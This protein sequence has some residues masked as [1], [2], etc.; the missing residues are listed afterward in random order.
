MGQFHDNT[1][2]NEDGGYRVARDELLKAEI[3]LRKQIEAVAAMRRALPP[4]GV[5]EDYEF[6][7]SSGRVRLSE[8][9]ENGRESLVIYSFMYGPDWEAPCPM[10]TAMLDGMDGQIPHVR[11]R[12]NFAVVAKAP[13]AK[14]EAF[15]ESRGWSNLPLLSSEGNTYNAD[16]FAEN[17][18]GQWPM[19]NVFHR[20]GAEVRHTWGSELFLTPPDDGLHNRHA[21]L[22]WPLWAV[23]D[24]TPEGRGTDWYP[25]LSYD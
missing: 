23:F 13:I 2:P 25:A 21:D 5:A 24:M 6:T 9:F 17:D 20:S 19:I 14:I 4:G 12:V 18:E 15:A 10:C 3:D 8:L 22:I 16:Y 1:F 11:Q 7:S